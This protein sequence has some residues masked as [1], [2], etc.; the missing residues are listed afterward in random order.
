[1]G[2]IYHCIMTVCS[3]PTDFTRLNVLP[4]ERTHNK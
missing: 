4:C 2:D 3:I 1:V